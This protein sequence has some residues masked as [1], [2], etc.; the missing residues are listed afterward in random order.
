MRK[1][2]A[3]ALSATNFGVRLGCS[4]QISLCESAIIGDAEQGLSL[5]GVDAGRQLHA[6]DVHPLGSRVQPICLTGKSLL[7]RGCD[8][9]SPF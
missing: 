8:V 4:T 6:R 9:S 2:S 3:S 5:C 1:L 7:D